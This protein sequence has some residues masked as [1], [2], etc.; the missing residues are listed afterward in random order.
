MIF[1]QNKRL[2]SFLVLLFSLIGALL[3]V[4]ATPLTTKLGQAETEPPRIVIHQN[5][6]SPGYISAI[7]NIADDPS[8]N[9]SQMST[10]HYAVVDSQSAC[11]E[12]TF[13]NN[14]GTAYEKGDYIEITGEDGEIYCFRINVQTG[15][16]TYNIYKPSSPIGSVKIDITRNSSQIEEESD[17]I[18]AQVSGLKNPDIKYVFMVEELASACNYDSLTEAH[19][20]PQ[21]KTLLYNI[22]GRLVD[23]KEGQENNSRTATLRYDC[24]L[25][26]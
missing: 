9:S 25:R 12:N 24:L 14:Q 13:N 26:S 19:K 10:R 23:Y 5:L 2:I 6:S 18:S 20:Q 15:G 4:A 7:D 11:D 3:L 17:F 21:S 1:E 22:T 16:D 8:G